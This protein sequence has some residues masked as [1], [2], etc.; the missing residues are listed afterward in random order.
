MRQKQNHESDLKVIDSQG[1]QENKD[2]YKQLADISC[3]LCESKNWVRRGQHKG[4]MRVSCRDCKC[5]Y[6]TD[7]DY[8]EVKKLDLKT[9]NERPPGLKCPSCGSLN[10]RKRGK[11]EDT[12]KQRYRCNECNRSFVENPEA[13][14]DQNYLPLGEDV[15]SAVELGYKPHQYGGLTK[16][17]FSQIQQQWLKEIAKKFIKYRAATRKFSTLN[18]YIDG[19]RIFSYFLF[20]IHPEIQPEEINRAI[21]VDYLDYLNKQGLKSH[22]KACMIRI[23]RQLIEDISRNEWLD[24]KNNLIYDE[25]IPKHEK[26]LPRLIPEEVISQLNEHLDWLPTPVMRMVIVQQELGLRVGELLLLPFDCLKQD[27]QGSWWIQFMREKTKRETSL[28]ISRELA[29]VI[30]EQ[31]NYIRVHLSDFD[32][33]FCGQSFNPNDRQKKAFHPKAKV[34]RYDSFVAF[35]RRLAKKFDIRTNS[36]EAWHFQTHQFRHTVAT[37]MINN[38][39]PHHIVQRFLGHLSPA[40]TQVYAHIYDETLKKQI[41]HF[42]EKVVNIAGEVVQSQNPEIDQDHDLQWFKKKIIGEVLP[43]GY[44]GLPTNL[45]CSKGNACLQCGHFRTTKEFLSHHQEH[46]QRTSELLEKAK[47]NN[48]TRQVQVNEEILKNL[49]NIIRKLEEDDVESS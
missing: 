42:H 38:Q 20:D 24:I 41:E 3:L 14:H 17:V 1:Q 21:I 48:W 31:Q 27:A 35:L 18:R 13:G 25:D 34:M 26:S 4:K 22:R 30:I 40:M 11:S 44:C 36:G 47:E 43:H 39:V 10:Y 46:F 9:S 8:L 29:G 2:I 32:Y 15:W 37:R 19:I 12:G 7:I 23:L 6:T 16:I 49:S 45:T 28:P 33:L 5:G